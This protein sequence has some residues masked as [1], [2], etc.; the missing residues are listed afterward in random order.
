LHSPRLV[1]VALCQPLKR[2]LECTIVERVQGQMTELLL[3]DA[4]GLFVG[5]LGLL[6]D[7]PDG[8]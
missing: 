4:D 7:D 8:L 3:G 2:I 1:G 6:S 5:F